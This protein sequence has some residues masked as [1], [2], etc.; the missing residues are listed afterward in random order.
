MGDYGYSKKFITLVVSF[1]NL[2]PFNLFTLRINNL[3]TEIYMNKIKL[4]LSAIPHFPLKD[5]NNFS[6]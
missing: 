3:R 1:F 2:K 4:L 5:G 6:C